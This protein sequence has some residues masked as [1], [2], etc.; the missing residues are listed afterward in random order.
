MSEKISK[1]Q[2]KMNKKF[3]N[4][5]FVFN[6]TQHLWQLILNGEPTAFVITEESIKDVDIMLDAFSQIIESKLK[7]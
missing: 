3:P 5:G 7:D 4:A 1:L 6:P 2:E